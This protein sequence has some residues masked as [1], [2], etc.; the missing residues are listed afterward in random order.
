MEEKKLDPNK[1]IDMVGESIGKTR[2]NE[3][4]YAK[5]EFRNSLR[6]TLTTNWKQ[7]YGETVVENFQSYAGKIEDL[8]FEIIRNNDK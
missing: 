8:L 6:Q 5:K 4:S 7:T 3:E 1:V 2:R